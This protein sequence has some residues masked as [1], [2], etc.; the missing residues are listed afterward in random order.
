M[1]DELSELEPFGLQNRTT[2]ETRT[3]PTRLDVQLH[4]FAI[5]LHISK[6]EL[7]VIL[8]FMDM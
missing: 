4:P 6:V 7:S 8:D 3:Q 2:M 1:I 5:S